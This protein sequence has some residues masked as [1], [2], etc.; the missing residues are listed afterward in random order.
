MADF[1]FPPGGDGVEVLAP[2]GVKY[3]WDVNNQRW[4]IRGNSQTVYGVVKIS[5]I[6]PDGV[7]GDLWYNTVQPGSHTLFI[8]KDG[9]WEQAA[10]GWQEF[11]DG[12]ET[13]PKTWYGDDPPTDPGYTYWWDTTLLELCVLYGGM[14]FPATAIQND[15]PSLQE[16]LENSPAV[17]TKDIYLT[18]TESDIIDISPTE[19]R[20]VIG[21]VGAGTAPKFELRHKEGLDDSLA[22]FEIDDDGKR[23]DIEADGHIDNI[24][25]KFSDQDKFI[26]NK[27]GDAEFTGRVKAENAVEDDELVTYQQLNEVEQQI[28]SIAPTEYV[29]KDGS[30][31]NGTLHIQPDTTTNTSLVVFAGK[32]VTSESKAAVFAVTDTSGNSIFEVKNHG[33]IKAGTVQYTPQYDTDIVTKKYVDQLRGPAT[34]AW[35]WLGSIDGATVPEPGGFYKS[36]VWLRISFQSANNIDLGYDLFEDTTSISTQYGPYGT[37]WK[38]I[39][40]DNKWQLMRQIRVDRFRWNYNDHHEYE[41]SSSRGRDWDDLVV[42]ETYYVTIGGFF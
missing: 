23:L 10:P 9:V 17:T 38:Y 37:I 16:V 39:A 34:L 11:Q 13:I 29:R 40:E 7:D 24:H 4:G 21:T 2:N 8:K 41:L 12:L 28:E 22:L 30:S 20:I 35:R 36:S 27:T 15:I 33:R 5:N 6:E 31:M 25:F 19:A 26:L 18:N 3:Y 32:E 1:V 42:G 14:W